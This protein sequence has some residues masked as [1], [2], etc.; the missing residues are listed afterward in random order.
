M[1][2]WSHLLK[3]YVKTMPTDARNHEPI[4]LCDY[5]LETTGKIHYNNNESNTFYL[6]SKRYLLNPITSIL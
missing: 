1:I 2:S 3:S 6:F 4:K 5:L